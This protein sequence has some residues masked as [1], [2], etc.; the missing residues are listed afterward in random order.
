[1]AKTGY[2]IPQSCVKLEIAPC[3]A[4]VCGSWTD[5]SGHFMS[6]SNTTQTRITAET[7]VFGDDTPIIN[8]GKRTAVNPLFAGLYTEQPTDA[9][10]AIAA[11]FEDEDCDDARYCARWSPAGGAIGDKQYEVRCGVIQDFD[12]PGGE[13]SEASPIPFSFS[14]FSDKIHRDTISS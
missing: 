2:S 12:Y 1:M 8:G 7:Q 14:L 13:A 4:G 6:V 5:I 9:F 3:A 11:K 10:L